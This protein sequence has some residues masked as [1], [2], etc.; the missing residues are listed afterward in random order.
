MALLVVFLLAHTV[1][2]RPGLKWFWAGVGVVVIALI[3]WVFMPEDDTGWRP[4]TFDEELAALEAKRAIPDEENAAR[5]YNELLGS[6]EVKLHGKSGLSL[7]KGKTIPRCR[8]GSVTMKK[9]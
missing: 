5:I 2:P 9:L 4:Y 6:Y 8:S 1:L 3:I 7:G